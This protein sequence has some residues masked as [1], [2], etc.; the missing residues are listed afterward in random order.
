MD[1]LV[2]LVGR[3]LKPGIVEAIEKLILGM[4][5]DPAL[6]DFNRI[7]MHNLFLS[8]IYN[9]N[10]GRQKSNIERFENLQEPA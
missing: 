10:E 8:Y 2:G 7:I 1:R 3:L 5:R 9:A 4:I 6:D